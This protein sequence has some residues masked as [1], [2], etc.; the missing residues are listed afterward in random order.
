[1]TSRLRPLAAYRAVASGRRLREWHAQ[2]TTLAFS[3][4]NGGLAAGAGDG[5]VLVLDVRDPAHTSTPPA[6]TGH[7][8]E[9]LAVAF[10]PG[11]R[12]LAAVASSGATRRTKRPHRP[13]PV[14]ETII[15]VAGSDLPES[16]VRPGALP[17]PSRE[18]GCGR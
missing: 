17:A 15:P 7:G 12:T 5:R 11:G 18:Q 16:S 2:T 13:G 4:D 10:S 1:M 3:P 9:V 8:A 6:F 14:R